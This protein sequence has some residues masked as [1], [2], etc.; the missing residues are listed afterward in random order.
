MDMQTLLYGGQH[1]L[2]K[3]D[4]APSK[5]LIQDRMK[6]NISINS[7]TKPLSLFFS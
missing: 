2:S 6:Q 3:R 1:K 4:V 7:N 5:I